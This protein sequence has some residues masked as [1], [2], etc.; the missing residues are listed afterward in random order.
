MATGDYK[1]QDMV[2]SVNLTICMLTERVS[3]SL[4]PVLCLVVGTEQAQLTL[5]PWTEQLDE[6][7]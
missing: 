3:L 5:H 6:G 2:L 1:S 7:G 4:A